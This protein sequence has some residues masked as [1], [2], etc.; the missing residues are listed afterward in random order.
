MWRSETMEDNDEPKAVVEAD[1]SQITRELA[2]KYD[3]TISILNFLEQIDTV[4][5]LNR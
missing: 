1:T 2:A 5:K 3:V 4:K